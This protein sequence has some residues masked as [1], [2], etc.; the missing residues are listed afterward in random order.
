LILARKNIYVTQNTKKNMNFLL[1]T[2]ALSAF[3]FT[4]S[5]TLNAQTNEKTPEA[6]KGIRISAGIDVLSPV[7]KNTKS[8]YDGGYGFSIQ[9]EMPLLNDKL[10]L[11]ANN[12]F[13]TLYAKEDAADKPIIG[14]M[15]RLSF[16]AGL[17]YFPVSNFYL[18]GEAGSS[19]LTNKSD[20]TG[21]KTYA[22]TFSPRA[23]YLLD[24]GGPSSLD[25]SARYEQTGA[26]YSSGKSVSSLGF[27]AAYAY[28]F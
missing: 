13:T 1:K 12:T 21:G 24:L 8:L 27:R 25:L 28:R 7:G 22:F 14:D 20:F 9:T 6:R 26:H 18:Q 5:L 10:F 23:G 2:T 15:K 16:R 11:T 19:M 4:G 3:L 17:R